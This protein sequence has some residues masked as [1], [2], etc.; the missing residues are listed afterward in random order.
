[1][2]APIP[3]SVNHSVNARLDEL[4]SKTGWLNRIDAWELQQ[5]QR[6]LE[7]LAATDVVAADRAKISLATLTGD[8]EVV[9]ARLRNLVANGAQGVARADRLRFLSN[10]MR[11]IEA[12]PLAEEAV[13][14]PLPLDT[15]E[16]VTLMHT[17]GAFRSAAACIEEANRR[18]IV[19]SG[20]K[21]VALAPQIAEAMDRLGVADSQVAQALNV[22][23]HCLSERGMIWLGRGP[24]IWVSPEADSPSILIQY[25][26]QID[27]DGAAQVLWDLTERLAQQEL[28]LPGIAIGLVGSEL[29]VAA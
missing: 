22:L 14:N 28:L 19:T 7:R 18:S 15:H 9:E 13:K 17:I 4:Y 1:M 25:E 20:T 16:V 26:L 11:A 10:R 8:D 2:P 5:L 27:A 23:G 21:S 12:L 6:D 29:P 24:D 3:H